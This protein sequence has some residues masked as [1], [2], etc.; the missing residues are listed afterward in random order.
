ML[1]HEIITS[2][3]FIVCVHVMHSETICMLTCL[4]VS[5]YI[6]VY[7]PDKRYNGLKLNIVYITSCKE[8]NCLI[9]LHYLKLYSKHMVC[10]FFQPIPHTCFYLLPVTVACNL[11]MPM[12]A[13]L[14][15]KP[16][17]H[18]RRGTLA[19]NLAPRSTCGETDLAENIIG[20]LPRHSL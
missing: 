12:T 1:C 8:I 17:P 16:L 19:L 6:Q 15:I 18:D 20:Q 4:N 11:R 2:L 10:C 7:N 3:L 5:V 9:I 13:H 14:Q